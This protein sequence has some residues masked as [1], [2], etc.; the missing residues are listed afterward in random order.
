ME[1]VYGTAVEV[2]KRV[3]T[4]AEQEI[5]LAWGM[6]EDL[7][8]LEKTMSTLKAVLLDA[9]KKQEQNEAL[10]VWL[11]RLKDVFLDAQDVLGEVE[12]ELLRRE[13][14]K[15]HGSIGRK[16]RRFFS[17]SN[18]LA[19]RLNI[20]HQIKAL[21][22]ELDDVA[23]DRIHFHLNEKQDLMQGRREMTSSFVRPSEII[24]RDSEKEKIVNMLLQKNH[25]DLI[26]SIIP[27]VGIGGLGKTALAKLVYN[28]DKVTQEFGLKMWVCVQQDFNVAELTRE[29][30]KSAISATST[31]NENFS[32]DQALK[33]TNDISN[34]S[35]DLVQIFLRTTL[36][37]KKI[38]LVL[39]DVWNEDRSKWNEVKDLL[40]TAC[41]NGSRI[42][43]T[44]RNSS[45]VS[46]MGTTPAHNLECL[47]EEKSRSLFFKYAFGDEQL[48]EQ[49]SKLK[50]FGKQI[51]QK[52]KGVPLALKT[53]GS[54][55]SSSTDEGEWKYVRDSE[56][57]ELTQ[58][59]N[60]PIL[61]ALRLSYNTM[62][63]QLKQ[64]FAH[65]SIVPKNIRTDRLD[66]IWMWMA[67]GIIESPNDKRDLEDIGESHFKALCA[68]SFFQYLGDDERLFNLSQVFE[69][70]DLIHQLASSIIKHEVYTV[71][72]DTKMS[73]DQYV[74]YLMIFLRESH[75]QSISTILHKLK[76]VRSIFLGYETEQELP[77][78]EECFLPTCISKFRYLRLFD[79]SFLSFDVLPTT[80]GTL[81]HLRYLNLQ[82]NKK[83]KKLPNSIC[84]L[85]SLQTLILSRCSELEELPKDIRY[86]INL[87][88]LF[89]TTKQTHFPENG[90]G[91]L[92][93]LRFLVIFQCRNLR[94]LPHDMRYCA[95]LRTLLIGDCEQ[96][97]LAIGPNE[98]IPMSLQSLLIWDSPQVTA[99][100]HWLQGAAHSLQR[101]GIRGC[102]NLVAL[103]EWFPNLTSLQKLFIFMCPKL[104]FLPIGMQR[105]TSLT[106]LKIVGCDALKER[107]KS[108]ILRIGQ[109]L[110]TF[111]TS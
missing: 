109:L 17:S 58:V 51:V 9:G 110:H 104:S 68:R 92:K 55:L 15:T 84:K 73:C 23:K 20:G 79:L 52:C 11:R 8:K 7:K 39:D 87:R 5:C 65:C 103:P 14:V 86:L 78:V 102:P 16:V 62:S 21:R 32:I 105:L 72:S 2:L 37:D 57:W 1:V 66:I 44:T 91:R 59:E 24:G 50:D 107:Y 75:G 98:V 74:R 111:Q 77:S 101:L 31:I 99:L 69:M 70:H 76:K 41:A 95:T 88:T 97:D 25:N 89:V 71:N 64:C 80:I 12:C 53:L 81:K 96:L 43:V 46:V 29:I 28:D 6:K 27:I 42:I 35:V 106:D 93:V 60:D 45:V 63:P 83:I 47:S 33:G 61:S 56:I 85:Q 100:P 34:L 26:I 82:G 94:S 22:Q 90:I 30:L 18:P 49:F 10:R 36:K 40:L 19:F 38:L 13:V 4:A 48:A 67:L 54:L 3:A 108:E